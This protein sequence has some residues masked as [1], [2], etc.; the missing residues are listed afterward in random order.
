MFENSSSTWY[1]NL[2]VGSITSCT[3]FQKYFL[4]KFAEETTMGSLMV[5]LFAAT[6]SLK[7]RVKYFN[8]RFTTILNKFHLTEKP[9]QEL[10]IEV[11][12]NVV[13][14]S[15]SMFVKRVAKK[16]LV[17]N[18]E[19]A[20]MIEFQ[21][22][23]CKEGQASLVKKE[24]HPPPRRGLLLTKPSGKLVEQTPGKGNGDIED[25]Q[26]MVK[27]L[28]NEIIDMKR[29]SGEVNQGQRPYKSF[30]KIN[31]PFKAIEPPPTNLNIDLGNVASN[32]FCTY[33]QENHSE[34]DCPQWVHAMNLMANRFLDE[35][36]LTG[37][38]TC[39]AMNIVD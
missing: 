14:A 12:A 21:M 9:T 20:K 26:C 4:D 22:K 7:E 36:S 1:F 3:K 18:F 6:M 19:E 2:P 15:I 8:Q 25:L 29:N 17:E 39:S 34:R 33:H 27:I 16:T 13:L 32:Y 10:Q 11:Y 31:P 35:V 5:E 28:S 38:P 37:Q 30:F 24:T 23:G